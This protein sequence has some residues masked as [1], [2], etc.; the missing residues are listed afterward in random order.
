MRKV[1]HV[2]DEVTETTTS[3]PID[4]L[5]AKRVVLLCKRAQT[6]QESGTS[7]FTAQ[8]GQGTEFVDYNKWISNATNTNAQNLTRVASLAIADDSSS[9]FLTMSP[10][11][12]FE[13]IKVKV[14]ETTDGTHSAWLII[15]YA[16]DIK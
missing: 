15:D 12:V 11:D 2:F 9:D 7:T 6:A 16:D 3:D 14:T 5:G 10:E 13:F 4:I 8:V 1:I